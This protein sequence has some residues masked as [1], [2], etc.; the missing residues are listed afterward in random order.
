MLIVALF[1]W[2]YGL[3]W[4]DQIQRLHGRLDRAVET[5]SIPQLLKTLFA[6]FRQ[7]SAGQVRGPIGVQLRAWADRTVSRCVGAAVRLI[8]IGIGL[9]YLALQVIAGVI[10]LVLWPLLPALPLVA[11]GLVV[12]GVR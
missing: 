3:G 4:L 7:I 8:I 9:G 11:I 5:F 1:S 2:W 6:P 10:W 12:L